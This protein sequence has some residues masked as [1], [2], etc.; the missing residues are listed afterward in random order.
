MQCKTP[1]CG[2][3]AEFVNTA[4]KEYKCS[5]CRDKRLDRDS[6]YWFPMQE[7]AYRTAKSLPQEEDGEMLPITKAEPRNIYSVEKIGGASSETYGIV[8][9][10][11]QEY[12][13]VLR[14]ES[15]AT[16]VCSALNKAY[17]KG[18][19]NVLHSLNAFS[20]DK[21]REHGILW[22]DGDKNANSNY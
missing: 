16:S 20:L 19:A 10:G 22:G 7:H 4:T 3:R 5:V 18:A 9:Q 1:L 15:L 14:D 17:K 11:K 8:A 2:K 12:V 13:I 21:R 6:I